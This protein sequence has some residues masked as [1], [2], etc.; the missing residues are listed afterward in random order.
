MNRDAESRKEKSDQELV[1][2]S[3]R[4]HQGGASGRTRRLRVS[5]DAH[6]TPRLPLRKDKPPLRENLGQPFFPLVIVVNDRLDELVDA[7]RP[8]FTRLLVPSVDVE[9]N[10][11][12]DP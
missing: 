1:D 5:G 8:L 6:D 2:P 4:I 3:E 10:L 7:N 12:V 11:G 9:L